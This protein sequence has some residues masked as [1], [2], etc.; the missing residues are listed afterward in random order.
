[1]FSTLGPE[2]NVI[3]TRSQKSRSNSQP[4]RAQVARACNYCRTNRIKCDEE[5]PCTQC[6]Q[7]GIQCD[8]SSKPAAFSASTPAA[9]RYV[10]CTSF[11]CCRSDLFVG[12]TSVS[13]I[14]SKSLKVSSSRSY[15]NHMHMLRTPRKS[16]K[17]AHSPNQ[18]PQDSQIVT[19][20]SDRS[21]TARVPRARSRQLI[22]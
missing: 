13:R 12:R 8:S 1:M 11:F 10:Y 5:L 20:R 7:R 2:M 19:R 15:Q 18:D 16:K 14:A 22:W 6:R 9:S 21:A 3:D 17:A 4:K